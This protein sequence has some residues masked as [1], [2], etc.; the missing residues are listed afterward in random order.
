MAVKSPKKPQP[1]C[2]VV[3]RRRGKKLVRVKV[4][5]QPALG[6]GVGLG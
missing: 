5:P 6:R 1:G 4:C 2:N 3:S